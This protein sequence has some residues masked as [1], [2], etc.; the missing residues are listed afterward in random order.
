MPLW[1][2][3]SFVPLRFKSGYNEFPNFFIFFQL[4]EVVFPLISLHHRPVAGQ[5]KFQHFEQADEKKFREVWEMNLAETIVKRST[6]NHFN[7]DFLA[8]LKCFPSDP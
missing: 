7:L 5:E 6:F 4:H 2:T 8:H 3:L 1:A